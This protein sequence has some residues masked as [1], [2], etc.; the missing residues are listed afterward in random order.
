MGG[1]RTGRDV[2]V[3][4]L[5]GADEFWIFD[6][7]VN[8]GWMSD[9]AQMSFEY[10]SRRNRDSR[11]GAET[12]IQGGHRSMLSIISFSWLKKLEGYFH[13]WDSAL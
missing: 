12:T 3:G 4:A 7:T 1:L 9:D 2:V 13:Q 8:R 11:S 6:I 10:L 5:L